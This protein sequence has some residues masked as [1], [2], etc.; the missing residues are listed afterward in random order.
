MILSFVNQAF[1][2]DVLIGRIAKDILQSIFEESPRYLVYPFGH[3]SVFANLKRLMH[4]E[5]LG[6]DETI[7]RVRSMPDLL[8]FDREEQKSYLVEVKFR[9]WESYRVKIDKH[10]LEWYKTYWPD[11]LL[12]YITHA[13][14]IFYCQRVSEIEDLYLEYFE[15]L[16]RVF[17]DITLE[18]LIKYKPYVSNLAQISSGKLAKSHKPENY[19]YLLLKLVGDNGPLSLGELHDRICD[20]VLLSKVELLKALKS[21]IKGVRW[22]RYFCFDK[23]GEDDWEWVVGLTHSGLRM[24]KKM[25]WELLIQKWKENGNIV[26]YARRRR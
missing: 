14:S 20:F 23:E 5:K 2:K 16:D 17:P 10:K 22:Y 18:V 1:P 19:V 24:Y 4:R 11:S 8:I 12:V 15:R 21:V 6:G 26:K 7:E 9:S 3:E 13:Y 25:D